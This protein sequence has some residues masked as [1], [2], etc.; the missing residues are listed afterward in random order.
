[1]GRATFPAVVKLQPVRNISIHAL[2]GEGDRYSAI[3]LTDARSF[4]STPSV[5]RAT[6]GLVAMGKSNL[7]ISIH[8]LR[9]EGDKRAVPRRF[10]DRKFQSTP[11]VGRATRPSDIGKAI[12][13]AFQSTPS[14]GRATYT[15]FANNQNEEFQSTPSVGRATTV[16]TST[17]QR[18]TGISIHALRGEGDRG[19]ASARPPQEISI[20]ALRG[21][22][23]FTK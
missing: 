4:Q 2:R 18:Y 13:Y 7:T 12:A 5:G 11:S 1:M 23:D 15:P 9:G 22:G 8:A 17:I 3:R 14:V 10:Y 20:H 6:G 16:C 19:I 21:E